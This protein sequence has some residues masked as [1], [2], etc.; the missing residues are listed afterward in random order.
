MPGH[1]SI[2]G[3]LGDQHHVANAVGSGSTCRVTWYALGPTTSQGMGQ[4]LAH[5]PPPWT[6]TER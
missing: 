5:L 1:R 3:S 2:V 4:L 6:Y